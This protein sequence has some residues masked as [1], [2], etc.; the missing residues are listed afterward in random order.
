MRTDG[1]RR[2]AA[3][4]DAVEGN[5]DAFSSSLNVG[6]TFEPDPHVRQA[7]F[8]KGPSPSLEFWIYSAIPFQDVLCETFDPRC[9]VHIAFE[10]RPFG[11][12]SN[13]GRIDLWAFVWKLEQ[14]TRRQAIQRGKKTSACTR[15][16]NSTFIALPT[17]ANLD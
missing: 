9:V 6:P 7:V 10:Y 15:P 5:G 3:G 14:S 4:G 16:T 12:E 2:P 13:I 1:L 17:N 11:P 8:T